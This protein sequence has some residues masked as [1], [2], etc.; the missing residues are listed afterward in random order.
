MRALHFLYLGAAGGEQVKRCAY[1]SYP[2]ESSLL[3][4][5]VGLYFRTMIIPDLGGRDTPDTSS[6]VLKVGSIFPL[7]LR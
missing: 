1:V 2:Q 3:L 5:S 4:P 7:I 6:P